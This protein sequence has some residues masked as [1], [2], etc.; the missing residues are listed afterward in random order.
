[1]GFL[2]KFLESMRV[3]DDEDYEDEYF[4]E[5]DEY[6]EPAPRARS[7][8]A[9]KPLR[10]ET[11]EDE[12]KAPKKQRNSASLRRNARTTSNGNS[13]VVV[14]P[15]SVD[16]SREITDTLLDNCTVVLNMEGL[17]MD[18][19]QRIIDFASGS[20]YAIGGNLQK[21]SSHIFIITP[22][23]VDIS[24]DFQEILSGAFDAPMAS[25]LQ[26]RF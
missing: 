24:G 14:K 26:N 8:N 25:A 19:A 11:I 7:N 5:E 18:V 6:E 16:E 12:E 23:S 1:M 15:T 20:T 17:D 13:V 4:D 22:K 3:N 2:D 9:K 21:I 10:S